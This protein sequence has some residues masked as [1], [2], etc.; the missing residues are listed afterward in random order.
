L[1]SSNQRAY[2]SWHDHG[3][4]KSMVF[5]PTRVLH[6]ELQQRRRRAEHVQRD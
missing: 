1:T 3:Q 5:I 2:A 6:G 4:R